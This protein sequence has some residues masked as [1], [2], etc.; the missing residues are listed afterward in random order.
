M[1]SDWERQILSK[2]MPVHWAGFES[3]TLKLQ[4]AGWE[5]SAEQDYA[6]LQ[7][8]LLMRHQAF[9]MHACSGYVDT[10]FFIDQRNAD[11]W[12]NIRFPIQW[13]TGGG[14]SVF[15]V[16]DN[17][18]GMQPVDMHPQ[19]NSNHR[20][21][22]IED[23]NLFAAPLVRTKEIIVA[24]DSVPELMDRILELQDPMRQKYFEDKVREM[25]RGVQRIDGPRPR[26]EFHAQVMSLVA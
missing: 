19:I 15:K 4:Q 11:Y 8:R 14:V 17:F 25:N 21:D 20:V 13:M 5:F 7:T 23:L 6:S 16:V 22:A 24:P 12:R 26:Q 3:T 10:D 2:P 9:Q 18:D 1:F